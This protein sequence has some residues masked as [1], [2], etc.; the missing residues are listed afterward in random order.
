[1]YL[2]P[3]QLVSEIKTHKYFQLRL[4]ARL[5]IR[6]FMIS[7]PRGFPFGLLIPYSYLTA[8]L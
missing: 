2:D 7:L 6:S 4:V 5:S 1:M 8:G 3:Y